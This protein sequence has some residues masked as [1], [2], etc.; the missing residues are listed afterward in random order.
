VV[1]KV[2]TQ[3]A[4][5]QVSGQALGSARTNIVLYRLFHSIR[6]GRSDETY[7]FSGAAVA[8]RLLKRNYLLAT[9]GEADGW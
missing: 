8:R 4:P 2:C 5:L 9:G 6:S 3:A 1:N 7:L